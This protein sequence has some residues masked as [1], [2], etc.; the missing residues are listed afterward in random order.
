MSFSQSHWSFTNWSIIKR[1]TLIKISVADLVAAS[2]AS[3]AVLVLLHG[4]IL[5]PSV[6]A[7]P[8]EVVCMAGG[9]VG[10][11]LIPAIGDVFVVIPMAGKT[12][13]IAPVVTGVVADR[14][15][16]EINGRPTLGHVAVVTLG[17]GNEVVVRALRLAT[18]GREPI[19]A[20]AASV[21]DSLVIKRGACKR[22]CG[23]AI[24]AIER[25]RYVIGR[26]PGC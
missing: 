13:H 24:T 11:V 21:R 8:L 16:R 2:A 22:R 20:A 14:R 12:S 23:M 6:V 9:A 19:V 10:R 15:V 4:P 18:D 1:T 7:F 25:R 26:H 5:A 17:H 3:A